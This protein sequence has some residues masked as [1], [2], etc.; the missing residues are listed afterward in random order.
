MIYRQLSKFFLSIFL[1]CISAISIS[2]SASKYLSFSPFI[3][4]SCQNFFEYFF[5]YSRFRDFAELNS[6][7]K[8]NLKGHHLRSSLPPLPEKLSKITTDHRSNLFLEDRYAKLQVSA[9][10]VVCLFVSKCCVC[11]LF[12]CCQ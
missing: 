4:F 1:F 10:C 2:S 3:I 7:I 12:V 5:I 8:Q 11:C 6:Q 9:V